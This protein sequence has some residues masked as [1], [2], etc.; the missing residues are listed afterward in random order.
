MSAD[1]ERQ[2]RS[3]YGLGCP[4]GAFQRAREA[5]EKLP[6]VGEWPGDPTTIAPLPP[7]DAD[8]LNEMLRRQPVRTAPSDRLPPG[9]TFESIH[10]PPSGSTLGYTVYQVRRGDALVMS[11]AIVEGS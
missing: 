6:T 2:E 1:D 3:V 8:A 11:V 5:A 4:E 7:L 10:Y 9:W